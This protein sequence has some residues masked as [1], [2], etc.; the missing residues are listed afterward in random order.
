MADKYHSDTQEKIESIVYTPGLQDSGDLEPGT[1]TVTAAAAASGL[2][3]ADYSKALSLAK[4]GDARLVLKRIATRLAVTIDSMTAGHL[5]CRAYV[6]AQD[7]DHRLFDEDWTTTEAKL[8]IVET[9][10]GNKATI[11]DLLKDGAAH[12]FYFFFWVDSGNAVL[13]L[14]QLWERVVEFHLLHTGSFTSS[15]AFTRHGTGTGGITIRHNLGTQL[16]HGMI[17]YISSNVERHQEIVVSGDRIY[18]ENQEY[19]LGADEELRLARSQKGL[20]QVLA[21]IKTKMGI[22]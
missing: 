13:S 11:F 9:H 1:R 5:Y 21:Q 10:S 4:P 19:I 12:I 6:D 18:F 3:N 22:L 8:D 20:E 14:V 15:G 17:S 2:A 7:A 16:F